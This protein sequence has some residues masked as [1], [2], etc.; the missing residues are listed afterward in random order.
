MFLDFVLSR[1]GQ[2]IIVE[3]GSFYPVRSDVAAPRGAPALAEITSLPVDWADLSAERVDI[4]E[5]WVD[6]YGD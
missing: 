5:L 4:A 1:Q 6:L 3:I 2:Q